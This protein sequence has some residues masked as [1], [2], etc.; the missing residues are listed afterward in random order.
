MCGSV[1]C[2]GNVKCVVSVD[3]VGTLKCIRSVDEVGSVDGAGSVW[4]VWG[5]YLFSIHRQII[6]SV[7][8]LN[9]SNILENCT[10]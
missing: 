9:F 3:W 7:Y 2:L 4:S 1:E 6:L 8:L 10:Q 5:V